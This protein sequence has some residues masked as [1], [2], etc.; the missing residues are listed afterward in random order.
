MPSMA[1]SPT[2]NRTGER[3]YGRFRID[4]IFFFLDYHSWPLHH[5]R[6]RLHHHSRPLNNDSRPL[7]NAGRSANHDCLG[8]YR[9]PLL[10][11]DAR[12]RPVL[13]NHASRRPVLV[14]L[15]L[16]RVNFPGA[17]FPLM[18]GNFGI[19]SDRQIGGHCR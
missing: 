6:R 18:A 8:N 14:G 12:S 9:R 1:P 11:N 10:H 2:P 16:P 19:T 13:D 5:D 4:R 17:N 7:Y 3:I 15:N